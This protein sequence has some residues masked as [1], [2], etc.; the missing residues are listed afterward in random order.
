MNTDNFF[1][2]NYTNIKQMHQI[3]NQAHQESVVFTGVIKSRHITLPALMLTNLS[4]DHLFF[5]CD[6]QPDVYLPAGT[7]ITLS[8]LVHLDDTTL[9]CECNVT[10]VDYTLQENKLFIVAMFPYNISLM[11]RREQVRYPIPKANSS[12]YSLLFTNTQVINEN[13][14]QSINNAVTYNEISCGGLSLTIDTTKLTSVPTIKSVLIIK[15]KFPPRLP[16]NPIKKE[17]CSFIIIAKIFRLNKN[18]NEIFIRAKF[19]HWSYNNMYRKWN[20]VPA[21]RGIS[22]LLPYIAPPEEFSELC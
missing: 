6:S 22:Q 11:Q 13:E 16:E 1:C 21:H 17:C 5:S 8:F 19:S 18:G 15:C 12:F 14:W 2:K 3:I 7:E 9:P 4:H 10:V 20:I